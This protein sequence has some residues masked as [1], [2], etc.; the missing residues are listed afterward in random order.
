LSLLLHFINKI[1]YLRSLNQIFKLNHSIF[2]L[3]HSTMKKLFVILFLMATGIFSVNAQDATTTTASGPI[4]SKRGFPIL[5]QGGDWGVS[6]NAIP[7][8]NFVGNAFSNAGSNTISAAFPST[9]VITVRKFIDDNTAYRGMLRL[10]L[11]TTTAKFNS[12]NDAAV[13]ADPTSNAT[14]EDKEVSK[15]SNIQIGGGL[16]KRKGLGRVQGIYGAMATIGLGRG[17]TPSGTHTYTYGNAFSTTDPNPSSHN[18]D[19][20]ATSPGSRVTASHTAA[21]FNIGVL[22]F[23]GA[24]YFIAPK[25]SLG[26]EF[27]WGPS[28]SMGG[29]S[30]STVDTWDGAKSAI[31][32]TTTTS[33][34]SSSFG[35]GTG[36][37]SINLNF[38]F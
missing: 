2:K 9:N 7:V 6:F 38:F 13:Q 11:G 16:E 37:T 3:N 34:G 20:N 36:V 17:A 21:G 8:L 14:V 12:Q 33:A 23:I 24:E 32:T 10:D 35:F 28:F 29:K 5:P 1:P 30:T 26:A 25:L 15:N 27:Q 22:G 31:K 19:G 4:M 18:F